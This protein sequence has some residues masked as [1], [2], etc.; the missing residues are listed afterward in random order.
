MM[1]M[2]ASD[3]PVRSHVP[4]C[5]TAALPDSPGIPWAVAVATA[6]ATATR[7][8]VAVLAGGTV[9]VYVPE[10]GYQKIASEV[11]VCGRPCA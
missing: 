11:M 2:L 6:T 5:Q 3:M 4:V 9:S 7:A 1:V 10:V 8:D